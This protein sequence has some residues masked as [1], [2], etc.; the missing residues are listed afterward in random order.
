MYIFWQC[1]LQQVVH[2]VERQKFEDVHNNVLNMDRRSRTCFETEEIEADFHRLLEHRCPVCD[3]EESRVFRQF[4][5]LDQH[6]RREHEQFY[7]DL[8]VTHLKVCV[9]SLL[10]FAHLYGLYLRMVRHKITFARFPYGLDL[11]AREETVQQVR[12]GPAP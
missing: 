1:F 3:A 12:L 11:H 2:T 5:Q 9:M 6:V 4:K 8:C 10:N 7:C